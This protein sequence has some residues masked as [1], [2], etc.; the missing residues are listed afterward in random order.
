MDIKSIL[1]QFKILDK[2][3][4]G[5]LQAE[6]LNGKKF[7]NTVWHGIIR[8]DIS[9]AEFVIT[10][11]SLESAGDAVPNLSG[12]DKMHAK[13]VKDNIQPCNYWD[14][15][16]FYENGVM[17]YTK[18]V[19]SYDEIPNA[20]TDGVK[21]A[22]GVDISKLNLSDEE[23]LGMVIDDYTTMT[24]EQRAVF[25]KA[26]SEMSKMG[27][28]IDKLH[29][30]GFRGVGTM[31]LLDQK[32]CNHQMYSDRILKSTDVGNNANST[33]GPSWHAAS[34]MSIMHKTA[35]EADI[36]HYCVTDMDTKVQDA[37]FAEA[38]NDIMEKNKTLPDDKKVKTIVMGWGFYPNNPKYEEYIN[39][40]K[41]AVKSG[42]FIMS[43]N[44]LELY[45]IEIFGTDRNPKGDVNSPENYTLCTFD[46]TENYENC[47]KEFLDNY[48]H[49]PMQHLTIAHEDGTSIQYEG[50]DGGMCWANSVG[51]LYNDFLGIDP[52][53]TPED[54]VKLLIETSDEFNV[55][56]V[57]CGRLLNAEAAAEKLSK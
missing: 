50:R 20:P 36:L 26:K 7:E 51:A 29:E 3:R 10:G 42:I 37:Q 4:D 11:L 22:R 1:N 32:F 52:G 30:K 8:P 57:Y 41:E 16:C 33:E 9:A 34:M 14:D 18:D 43:N 54:F 49:L 40:C 38:I 6:E 35:P 55:Q 21:N 15:Y 39:L 44:T 12:F 27:L 23:L 45:G 31:A 17:L 5:W 46:K 47:S 25:E 53:L 24:D 56:G 28:G 19:K 2:N 13:L 48:L